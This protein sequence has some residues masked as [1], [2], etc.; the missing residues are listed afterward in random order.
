MGIGNFFRK[1]GDICDDVH[2]SLT[3]YTSDEDLQRSSGSNIRYG[4]SDEMMDIIMEWSNFHN[5][6]NKKISDIDNNDSLV[7]TKSMESL[8]NNHSNNIIDFNSYKKKVKVKKPK[9]NSKDDK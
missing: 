4:V 9:S 8:S 1:L 6:N 2:Y 3:A 5:G 7:S